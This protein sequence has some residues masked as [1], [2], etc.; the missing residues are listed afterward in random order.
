M[1]SWMTAIKRVQGC[2]GAMNSVSKRL[3][4]PLALSAA[5]GP[6]QVEPI[7]DVLTS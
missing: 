5:P 4:T 3:R 6:E 2:V 1:Q 7:A